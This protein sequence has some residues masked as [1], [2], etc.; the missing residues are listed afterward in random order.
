MTISTEACKTTVIGDGVLRTF[1]YTFR[2]QS[3]SEANLY[4]EDADGNVTGPLDPSTWSI[5]GVG[6]QS[7]GGT[8]TYPLAPAPVIDANTSLTLVRDT[9][10]T[11]P[12]RLINQGS[13]SPRN[14]EIA[15]D[16]LDLQIQQLAEASSRSVRVNIVDGPIDDLV[17]LE[18]RKGKVVGF[19]DT[20]G[21]ITLFPVPP[22]ASGSTP[23]GFANV[24]DYG[25]IG[26]GSTDD[27]TAIRAAAATGLPLWFP[28]G[29][30]KITGQITLNN[31]GQGVVGVNRQEAAI[32]P[33]GSFNAFALSSSSGP[34]LVRDISLYGDNQTGGAMFAVTG[35]SNVSFERVEM[36]FA[37]IGVLASTYR[38]IVFIDC[39]W[40]DC[41]GD[42][43]VKLTA[44]AG[45]YSQDA[46]F[47]S[48]IGSMYH[49]TT[50]AVLWID[51]D[52]RN[53]VIDDLTT[54]K[55]QYGLRVS[56]VVGAANP[57]RG[58]SARALVAANANEECV[59]L[60]AGQNITL[61]A[62][63]AKTSTTKSGV[64]I[65]A[66]LTGVVF[67]GNA[68]GNRRYGVET[69]IGAAQV[70]VD[71]SASS[72]NNMGPYSIPND[73]TANE[74]FV[75]RGG[76]ELSP[77]IVPGFALSSV[78]GLGAQVSLTIAAG[79]IT[80]AA[81]DMNGYGYVTTP[82]LT[83][84]GDGAGATLTPTISSSGRLTSVAVSAPGAG[85]TWA[86]VKVV[87]QQIAQ[88]M[89]AFSAK[90][91]GT[92]FTILAD[93]AGSVKYGNDQGLGL[94][95]FAPA[96]AVNRVHILGNT[97]GQPAVIAATGTDT[98][99]S[100]D[101]HGKGTGGPVIGRT[102]DRIAFYGATPIVKGTI[103]GAKGGNVALANLLT[104]LASIGILT[105]STT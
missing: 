13:Y 102:G 54:N 81:V 65:G 20:T 2:I 44:T 89:R 85:Y 100:I 66:A 77:S 88:T 91:P 71:V 24:K 49:A 101:I 10:Y 103:T 45:G 28:G 99:I 1:T 60:D 37:W 33:Y 86:V 27:T 31:A 18:N 53:T 90:Y 95:V 52:I 30:Y 92:S 105:D 3:K 64:Y 43:A 48:C 34:V 57:P 80:A 8:F 70:T 38:G 83:V 40:T 55:G 9:P 15:L 56:N 23:D 78:D 36:S 41:Q 35:N 50:G 47:Q 68:S 25:A 32:Y 14:V 82:T 87:P 12:T 11:Q 62:S 74:A 5:T 59:R 72:S 84:I 104:Y 16:N 26:D 51:G 6:P 96:A 58:V 98:N 19:D 67:Q 61:I 7:L 94:E 17:S 46:K 42:Y 21:D 39:Q 22:A 4:Y 97:T 76:P 73:A 93:G 79:Q 29:D 75:A 69:A 63:E